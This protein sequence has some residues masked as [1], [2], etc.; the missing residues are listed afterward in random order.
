M[1]SCDRHPAAF[2]LA[3]FQSASMIKHSSRSRT[4]FLLITN[5]IPPTDIPLLFT[6]SLLNKHLGCFHFWAIMLL[7][8]F[9]HKFLCR[10]MSH[11]F[12]SHACVPGSGIAGSS[13]TPCLTFWGT[14]KL[15]PTRA[16][17][18]D[19]PAS[20]VRGCH[21]LHGPTNTYYCLP[22]WSQPS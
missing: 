10:N 15:F 11:V 6:H 1:E 5:N 3:C 4:S 8:T 22:L 16:A 19:T 2:I 18:F 20:D 9:T 14:L 13:A 12:N 7:W 17:P 21:F